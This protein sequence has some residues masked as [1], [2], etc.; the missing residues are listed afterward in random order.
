MVNSE[1]QT[2]TAGKYKRTLTPTKKVT[3][4]DLEKSKEDL[5]QVLTLFKAFVKENRPSLD[6]DTVATGETWFGEDAL[7]KGL[8]DELRTVDDVLCEF[9]D[10]G[11]NVYS[12]KYDP[13]SPVGPLGGLL[14]ATE[15][16]SN[17]DGGIIK[18]ATKWLVR[19]ISSAVREEL[20]SMPSSNEGVQNR[21][22]MKDSRNVAD[23][24]KIEL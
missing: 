22:M 6:I 21:Y 19:N 16:K 14:P 7:K 9:V 17:N 20:S 3:D 4:E 24:I 13:V 23:E 10:N 5:E 12:V 8:C 15:I 18:G 11:Y 1:F 2:V